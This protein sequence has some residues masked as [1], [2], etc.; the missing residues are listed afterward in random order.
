MLRMTLADASRNAQPDA[1]IDSRAYVVDPD[2]YA[3]VPSLEVG[4]VWH[5]GL[6]RGGDGRAGADRL[7][8]RVPG[9]WAAADGNW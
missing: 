6:R 7:Q 4:Y 2:A 5:A 9:I 3:L 1:L 8:D